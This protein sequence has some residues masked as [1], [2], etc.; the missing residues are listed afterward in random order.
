MFKSKDSVSDS[1]RINGLRRRPNAHRLF[2]VM[3]KKHA[4]MQLSEFLLQRGPEKY[5]K[6]KYD[7]EGSDDYIKVEDGYWIIVRAS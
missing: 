7:L 3:L 6:I 2:Q 5:E 4:M 1:F